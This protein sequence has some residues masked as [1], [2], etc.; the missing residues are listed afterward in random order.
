MDYYLTGEYWRYAAKI[1][2]IHGRTPYPLYE[3]GAGTIRRG[4]ASLA[5]PSPNIPRMWVQQSAKNLMPSVN[6]QKN[7][8]VIVSYTETDP[9]TNQTTITYLNWQP[10]VSISYNGQTYTTPSWDDVY[11]GLIEEKLGLNANAVIGAWVSPMSASES[12]VYTHGSYA[13]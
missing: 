13:A 8:W 7:A 3:L 2:E 6:N 5:R 1:D 11:G 12:D 10:G 9:N 4:P